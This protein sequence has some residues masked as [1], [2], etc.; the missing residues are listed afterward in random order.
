V[1]HDRILALKAQRHDVLDYCA[2]LTD[3]QLNTPRQQLQHASGR[4]IRDAD[5][6]VDVDRHTSRAAESSNDSSIRAS[7]PAGNFSAFL[8]KFSGLDAARRAK[9]TGRC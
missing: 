3:D 2:E 5:I 6:A 4:G 1:A 8:P 9:M 7:A